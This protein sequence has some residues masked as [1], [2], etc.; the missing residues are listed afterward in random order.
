[1]PNSDLAR[2][3]AARGGKTRIGKVLVANNGI[4]AVKAI[5]SI[6]QWAY[7]VFGNEREVSFNDMGDTECACASASSEPP[8]TCPPASTPVAPLSYYMTVLLVCCRGLLGSFARK[9]A[10]VGCVLIS[11]V[12]ARVQAVSP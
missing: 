8:V 3:V 1:M 6:R 7:E 2:Y 9:N 11:R 4:A 5:R 10:S 12:L